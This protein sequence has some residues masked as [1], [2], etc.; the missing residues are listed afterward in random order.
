MAREVTRRQLLGHAGTAAAGLAGL[1]VAGCAGS[2]AAVPGV[3][4]VRDA[5][6][7]RG[8]RSFITRPDLNP[9]VITLSRKIEGSHAHDFFLNAPA[10]GPRRGGGM[11]L[12]PNGSL[13]WMGPDEPGA[14]K[15][16]FNTQTYQGKPVLTW[17]EGVETHG[18]GQ[19]QAVIADSS[20]RRI[21]TLH[22]VGKNVKLDHH[23][24][25]VTAKNTALVTIFWPHNNVDCTAVGGPKNA[26]IVS[27][28]FEELD[29]VTG[30]LVFKWDSLD[31]VP[32]AWSYE[33]FA[34]GTA[35]NPYDYFHINSMAYASD[36]N[37]LVSSRDTW[38]IYKISRKDG[39]I[40]WKLNGKHSDFEMGP[41]THFYWQ[42]HVRP[43]ADGTLTVFD[44]GASPKEEMQSR[45]L[46]LDVNEKTMKVTLKHQYVHPGRP[47]LL[48]AA[49]GS[50]QLLPNGNVV[51]GWGTNP[52]FSEFSADG[53]LLVGGQ[54][55]KGN[56]SYRVFSAD[57]TGHPTDKPTVVAKKRK[58]GGKATVYV[59]WNGATEVVSWRVLSGKGR[60]SLT[61]VGSGHRSG[62]ETALAVQDGGPYYAVQ[63]L[64]SGG[65]VLGTS[66][67]V[68]IS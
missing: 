48:A 29:P 35:G 63:G 1:G 22:A 3:T 36:G 51:V 6:V 45:G 64:D 33:E 46:I 41:G 44:N 25:N 42:H 67:T 50:C 27:G 68:K 15:L 37:I 47:R 20:Y 13:I 23:E 14:H 61:S 32:I 40:I 62:F 65:H 43:H 4:V 26:S 9:P 28:V 55:T 38:C 52:Y 12:D 59:S 10:T 56:P 7:V 49:M 54:M 53:K 24:F 8:Y 31:H 2:S 57:W 66:G 58:T 16:D 11:I 17:W 60:S 39:H 19:G 21:H 30:K 34:G 18:W 5:K